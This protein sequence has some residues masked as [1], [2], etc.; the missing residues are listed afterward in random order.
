MKTICT[1]LFLGVFAVA[2][3]AQQGGAAQ[4]QRMKD[5]NAQASQKRL[6]GDERQRFVSSCVATAAQSACS[7]RAGER[8]LKGDAR[9]KFMTECLRG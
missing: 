9:R 1:A 8:K 6:N 7:R 4:Q 5:C 3:H 2:A